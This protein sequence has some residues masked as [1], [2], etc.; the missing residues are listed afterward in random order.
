MLEISTEK[1]ADEGCQRFF[2]VSFFFYR[3][4]LGID[5]HFVRNFFH[6]QGQN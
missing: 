3:I 4:V 5:E 1:V 2:Q 6:K